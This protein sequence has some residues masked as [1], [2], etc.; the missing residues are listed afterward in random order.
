M[1][2]IKVSRADLYNITLSY[3]TDNSKQELLASAQ[4]GHFLIGSVNKS[5]L[6]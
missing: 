3:L 2:Q 4:W 5:V 6:L 1:E